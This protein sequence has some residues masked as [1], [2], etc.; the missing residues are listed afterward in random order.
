LAVIA[1]VVERFG[2][3]RVVDFPGLIVP[4]VRK[5]LEWLPPK[6]PLVFATPATIW[7]AE[8]TKPPSG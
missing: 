3:V 5:H 1:L 6:A 4:D 2:R 7:H 8:G